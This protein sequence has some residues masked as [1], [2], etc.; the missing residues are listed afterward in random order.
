[1]SPIEEPPPRRGPQEL[2]RRQFFSW[3]S[4]GAVG[5]ASLVSSTAHASARAE[6]ND[7]EVVA[8]L[9]DATICTGC[10]ACVS[11]CNEVNN[12][13]PDPGVS[14]GRYQAPTALNAQTMNI[15]ALCG[16]PQDEDGHS[17]VKRQCMHCIDPACVSGC[18]FGAL[19]KRDDG[20]VQ[21]TPSLCI[22]C[23]F[24]EV[25]CP[26]EVPKFEWSKFNPEIVKCEFCRHRLAE[27]EEPGCT[28]ACPTGA[29]IFGNR[30][31]LL[32]DAHARI[33]AR[34]DEYFEQRVYGEHEVGG[35]NVLY[36]SKLPF[37]ELGLP[38]VP[39]YSIPGWAGTIQHWLY[40]WMAIPAALYALLV[41]IVWRRWSTHL[42]HAE[43]VQSE[44]GLRD[45]L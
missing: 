5:G 29:V 23:R 22:G 18:P 36:L 44:T 30:A 7:E 9:Y 16:D 45:Q 31:E 27:G 24:C 13:P 12:L 34:P 25:A 38:D 2:D 37:S 11:A 15:I 20:V 26:F 8:M 4:A 10:K 3:V 21:W 35:T 41:G 42:K 33:D 1:M 17:F 14:D 39:N 40:Y 43:H 19:D 32:A 6:Q 28:D